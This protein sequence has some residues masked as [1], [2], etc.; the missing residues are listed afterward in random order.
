MVLQLLDSTMF[1]QQ[2]YTYCQY[3]V[4]LLWSETLIV[5]KPVQNVSYNDSF[6]LE[7]YIGDVLIYKI[8]IDDSKMNANDVQCITLYDMSVG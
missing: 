1:T 7:I 4:L 3:D 5:F 8:T 2:F 6:L